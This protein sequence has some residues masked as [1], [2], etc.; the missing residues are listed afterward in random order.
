[1][2]APL[3]PTNVN[4]PKTPVA[5]SKQPEEDFRDCFPLSFAQ[6]RIWFL[7][8]LHPNNPLYNVPSGFRL[9]GQLDVEALSRSLEAVISRHE[10]LRTIYITNKG[11]PAQKVLD[12]W[13]F[14]LPVIDL[15]K[16]ISPELALAERLSSEAKIPFNLAHD[17]MIRASLFRLKPEE[18][19]LFINVHHIAFDEWSLEILVKEIGSFYESFLRKQSSSLP[20]LP[21][22]YADFAIWQQEEY[23]NKHTQKQ[24]DYWKKQLQGDLPVLEIRADR[25]R[26]AVRT[27]QGDRERRTLSPQLTANLKKL[28]RQESVTLYILLLSIFK[29]LLHRYSGMEDIIVGTPISGRSQSEVENLLGFFVN[30]LA[31]RSPVG[32]QASFK[33][34]LAKV[35]THVLGAFAHQELPFDKLIEEIHSE[36]NSNQNPLFDI[37]FALQNQQKEDFQFASLGLR[38]IEVHTHTAKFD[39]TFVAQ[40]KGDTLHLILEYNSDIFEGPTV[41]RMLAHFEALAEGIVTNPVQSVG[42]FSLINAAERSNTFEIW[43]HTS[44]DYPKSKTVAQLFS[45]QAKRTPQAIAVQYGEKEI[46]YAELDDRSNQVGSYLR[47][48]GIGPN[49]LVGVFM[50]RSVEMIVAWLGILKAGG[51]YVPLDLDYPAERI[52]FMIQDTEMPVILSN[53]SLASRIP[54]SVAKI[55]KL[56]ADSAEIKQ[57]SKHPVISTATAE[58]IAYV[59]YTSGS[60]GQPKG[61]MVPNRGIVRLVFNTNYVQLSEEERIA[62]ASN[63]SFDAATFEV[64][65]SLLHGGKLVGVTKEIMLAPKEFAAFLRDEKITSLFLTTALFNQT[66]AEDPTAFGT[67]KNV[68]FGGEACDP[69]SVRRVLQSMPPHRLLHVYGPTEVTT[70]AS[71][72]EVKTVAEGATTLPIGRPISNTTFHVLDR[73]LQEVPVGMAGELYLGGDGLALGYL[74]RPELTEQ[75]FIQNPADLSEKLYKTGDLVR[76]LPDGNIE[77]LGRMDNQVKIRGFR[78]EL[79]EVESALKSFPGVQEAVAIVRE[80]VPGDKR[81][82]GYIS[83]KESEESN[84]DGLKSALK[85]KMPSYMIP[86][87]IVEVKSFPLTPNGKINRKALPKPDEATPRQ[88]DETPR[89]YLE[90]QLHKIW[91][92]VLGHSSFGVSDNF[93]EVGGHSLLAVKLMSQIETTLG[94]KM[95]VSVLFQ[96][97][98]IEKLA[99][100]VRSTG[101]ATRGGCLVEIQP[102]GSKPPIFWLHTLGGGG[103]GGLFTYRKLAELLGR[104][105]PSYGLVA[106]PVPFT[107]IESMAAHYIE[108]IRIIQPSGPYQLGGYCFGGVVAYEMARQLEVK[109]L[110]VR[111]LALLDCSLPDNNGE[112]TK[113]SPK[114]AVHFIRTLPLW[115]KHFLA[116]DNKAIRAQVDDKLARIQRKLRRW[117]GLEKHDGVEH[118]PGSEL[119]ELIDMTHYP[120]DYKRYAEVHWEALIHYY[121]KPINGK[122]VLF[123]TEEPRLLRLDDRAIWRRM[124]QG[125]VEIRDVTGKHEEILNDPHVQP[126]ASQLRECLERG[127]VP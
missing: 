40:D 82:T 36:R 104:D 120:K 105:Q 32:D 3:A 42:K 117:I 6:Q 122:A 84:Q 71:W 20:E 86:A 17:L 119:G 73:Q 60:T 16:E 41:G 48:Q 85:L 116:Q 109:G 9:A 28:A 68:L 100:A 21:I 96:S 1:M 35:R 66:A 125:G 94:K 25:I 69:N 113:K 4:L 19:A 103:G 63:S 39:L 65:G 47:K 123:K 99:E 70:F 54:Q 7:D 93:F 74:R 58:N 118:K 45:E 110:P 101:A 44:T 18:H 89:S 87:V 88:G 90:T 34:V 91:E 92:T 23:A 5:T 37:V 55:L 79:E 121:A 67:L 38:P 53:E 8:Q 107:S 24:L 43:N 102:K 114:L 56:D 27:Y 106:P 11:T 78:I 108:E 33:E 26:P 29:T 46:S 59:I 15:S 127:I 81:L 83:W 2:I 98:T 62:Q 14:T 30:T 22:Q 13:K 57:E 97:A 126:L 111:L 12:Q 61:V 72:Y 49:V 50:E 115:L 75:K 95:P 77:F 76:F 124:I 51:A 52:A 80:D 10:I 64:W 31:I 112:R